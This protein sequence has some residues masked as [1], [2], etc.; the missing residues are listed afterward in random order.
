MS[1]WRDIRKTLRR[2]KVRKFLD[3]LY[4]FVVAGGLVLLVLVVLVSTHT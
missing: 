3:K 2:R 1:L 4:W